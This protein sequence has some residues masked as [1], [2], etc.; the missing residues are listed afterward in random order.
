M[1]VVDSA[2][3]SAFIPGTGVGERVSG[4]LVGP[5]EVPKSKAKVGNGV[6]DDTLPKN[7]GGGVGTG[8][9]WFPVLLPAGVGAEVR[10]GVVTFP[11]KLPA[12]VGAGVGKFM[13]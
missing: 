10:T 11:V 6:R 13:V 9:D 1:T 5:P 3:S 2:S 7:V 12:R 8:G 4:G